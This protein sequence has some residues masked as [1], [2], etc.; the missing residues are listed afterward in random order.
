M[1]LSVAP[2]A[3]AMPT[4]NATNV[5][6]PNEQPTG[7]PAPNLNAKVSKDKAVEIAKKYLQLTA[8]F[9][10]ESA[11]LNADWSGSN[12]V[13]SVWNLYF[14]KRVGDRSYGSAHAS[15]DANTGR[16]IS[17]GFSDYDP[18]QKPSFPPKVSYAQGKDVAAK[19][20]KGLDGTDFSQLKFNDRYESDVK[21]PLDGN[22]QYNYSYDRVVNG[23][24]FPQD[25]VSV[26]VDGNGRV[27]NFY[28]NWTDEVTFEKNEG[29]ITQQA[30][31]KAFREKSKLGLL[32]QVPY[33]GRGERK[34]YIAYTMDTFNLN[35]KT[36]EWWSQE[37]APRPAGGDKPISDKPLA[38][39][40]KGNLNLSKEEAVKKVEQSFNLPSGYVVQ[41]ASYSEYY[42]PENG[43][44]TSTWNLSWEAD[45]KKQ[46]T[47]AALIRPMP[48][49]WANVNA[50]TGEVQNY[51]YY[52]SNY[53]P[54][55][56][57]QETVK[58]KITNEEAK[59][60]AI[61]FVKKMVP[62]YAHELVYTPTYQ[63]DAAI[64]EKTRMLEFNFRHVSDGVA[65][66]Y[67]NIGVSID[68]V[69]GDVTNFYTNF[70]LT[71]YPDKK[72]EVMAEDKA[73][74]LLLSQ[75]DV[76]LVYT[77]PMNMSAIPYE[78]LKVMVA[79][80]DAPIEALTN[81]EQSPREA[82]L[83]YQL[84]SKY[85]REPFFL[86][87]VSG[88][89]KSMSTGEVV[90]LTKEKVTDIDDHWAKDALQL[91]LDY[92]ALEVTGGLVNPD[93]SITKGE[94]IKMLVIAMNGG[95]YA[96]AFDMGARSN[97]FADVQTSSKY[98]AFVE[99]ALDRRLIDKSENF[100]PEQ[101]I[102]RDDMA[103]LIVRA[104]GYKKLS[105]F[106][107]M[108]NKSFSDLADVKDAGAAAIAVG[109]GIMSVDGGKF[110]PKKEVTRAEA[111]SSFYRYLQKRSMLQESMYY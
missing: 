27:V 54:V 99:T 34:P 82:K 15:I 60:K 13:R 21:P 79:A 40:P 42:N 36:G 49:I 20:L 48:G 6:V 5:A 35:A 12:A 96:G 67:N 85:Q 100:N 81:S 39:K 22:V 41:N 45:P 66:S 108:F 107:G 56:G 11:N 26:N 28:S 109:L 29:V 50:K 2:A 8:D 94:M 103:Q 71:K 86:D 101:K 75:Y 38:E 97:T 104:L 83:V 32:Y 53:D 43:E 65:I 91:M 18:D 3:F 7:I 61:E 24:S 4:S 87:A 19:F 76:E 78:K 47:D 37:G 105:Q 51:N 98:F 14:D 106:D 72:P 1:L 73:K 90:S 84:V 74:E 63:P 80:G 33:Q 31:E 89:W 111:A 69:T 59:E 23:V 25:S 52:I 46:S 70:N 58:P 62:H 9:K 77:L 16:V 44:T 68:R 93:Q 30:A 88:Q 102:T 17:L 92:Q 10:L 64:L 57:K 110:V 95:Y 55:T